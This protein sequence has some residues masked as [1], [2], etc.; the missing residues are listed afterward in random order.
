MPKA[1]VIKEDRE[2]PFYQIVESGARLTKMQPYASDKI[3]RFNYLNMP[4]IGMQRRTYH[5]REDI[6]EKNLDMKFKKKINRAAAPQKKRERSWETAPSIPSAHNKMLFFSEEEESENDEGTTNGSSV[7]KKT[8]KPKKDKEDKPEVSPFSYQPDV[9]KIKKSTSGPHWSVSK[10]QRIT[11]ESN[12]KKLT[13]NP[14]LG[15]GKYDN[16][17]DD[18]GK[19]GT[20]DVSKGNASTFQNQSAY[21][22]SNVER[23]SYLEPKVKT[24]IGGKLV[25]GTV[26]TK[27]IYPHGGDVSIVPEISP[28]PGDYFITGDRSTLNVQSKPHHLQFFGSTQERVAYVDKFKPK[29]D[30]NADFRGPGAY[31]IEN[32]KKDIPRQDKFHR[33]ASSSFIAGRDK[34]LLFSGNSNPAPGDYR[35]SDGVNR[36]HGKVWSK[37]STFGSTE[38]RFKEPLA[39]NP[40]PGFYNTFKKDRRKKAVSG[41][42]FKSATKRNVFDLGKKNNTEMFNLQDYKSIAADIQKSPGYAP[43]NF[44][45]LKN[46]MVVMPFNS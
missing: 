16:N 38:K 7:I 33:G 6:D 41:Y 26:N 8:A 24:F 5:K 42:A 11:F 46:E 31:N 45:L 37:I 28:G 14:S 32:Y 2:S 9:Q 17:K 30:I 15:P 29:S 25:K 43:N 35:Q 27:S 20:I 34:D 4:Q 12:A 39:E 10:S 23:M 1:Y 22:K 44:T 36:L 3:D 21:F 13:T 40:G 19:A 18:V